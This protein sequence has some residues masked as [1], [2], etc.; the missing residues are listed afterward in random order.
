MNKC[1]NNSDFSDVWS[2]TGRRA[3]TDE[4]KSAIVQAVVVACKYGSSVQFTMKNGGLTF[5]PLDQNSF[6]GIGEFVNLET[7]EIVTLSK[8]GECDKFIVSTN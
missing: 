6:L 5:I 7:A 8:S 3:F 2:E 4:E 1:L